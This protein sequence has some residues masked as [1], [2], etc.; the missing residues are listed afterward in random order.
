MSP[1]VFCER[2]F[3]F[4]F[5]SREEPRLHIHVISENG[6]AKFWIE[7]EIQLAVNHGLPEHDLNTI[8]GILKERVDEV[9][10]AWGEHFGS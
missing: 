3:R 9:R 4:F 10:A 8:R 2:G 7:P 6:E 1:T 5:F